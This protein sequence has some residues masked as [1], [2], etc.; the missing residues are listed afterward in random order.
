MTVITS[1][2]EI[3][4]ITRR[5]D[6]GA[7]ALSVYQQLFDLLEDLPPDDWAAPTECTGW[8]VSD[9]VR[10]LLG[11]ARANAS[12]RE[13]ARQQLWGI[14][15]RR[16]Y[17]GNALDAVN[18]LQIADH[19][20]LDGNQLLEALRDIAPGAVKARMR[21]PAP[22]RAVTV[23]LAAGGSTATG[24][25]RSVNLGHLADII[26]TRDAW[27]HTIDITRAIGRPVNVTD[28]VN[29]RL[30]SD[31]VAEWV[32]RHGHSIDLTLTGPAGGRYRTGNGAGSDLIEYDAV[33]FC[34]V[35]SGRAA[36]QA[37]M[38]TRVVF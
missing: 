33:E 9:M 32:G 5:S 17:R 4:P 27:M 16:Q 19:A 6:A 38:A 15:H 13:N 1:V 25:P 2:S 36:G 20:G 12:M 14:R 35:L 21:T 28:R 23:P 22:I 29:R 3:E 26:Y 37:L 11:A 30:V 24:M 8:R 34:R 10:H 18:A 31:V 7:V